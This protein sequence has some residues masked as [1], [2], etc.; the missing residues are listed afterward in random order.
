MESKITYIYHSS[1]SVEM[2]N[3][4]LLFDYSSGQLPVWD[5]D[6]RLYVFASHK[7]FDHFSK[8]IF[9]LVHT[10]PN[11]KFILANEI[12][13]NQKYMDRWNVPMEARD[14]IFYVHKNCEYDFD[15]IHVRTLTSTDS[16][17]A[18]MLNIFG[19][20]I[21]H[22]G[23]LHWWTKKP[24][25]KPEYEMTPEK[26]QL[27]ERDF[28]RE[29]DKFPK[30]FHVDIAFIPLDIRLLDNFY[31]GLDYIMRRWQVDHVFC[32]HCWGRYDAITKLK[33][34]EISK[35]YK[36]RIMDIDREGLNWLIV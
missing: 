34:M 11:V 33:E 23:D 28:K 27:I 8:K 30:D 6:I 2:Q 26:E 14:K 36:D 31:K 4:V 10:Y 22:A 18:F 25:I 20:V 5:K 32:M 12:K 7:H 35:N 16:G 13:M 24:E 9:E 17:V 3:T 1:F 21:Y 29:I 19:K 15:D